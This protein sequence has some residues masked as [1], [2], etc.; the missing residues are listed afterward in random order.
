MSLIHQ[1]GMT[2]D[3]PLHLRTHL[4]DAEKWGVFMLGDLGVFDC[5][6][7]MYKLTLVVTGF[8][9]SIIKRGLHGG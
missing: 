9:L 3:M 8:G 5:V 7:A 4:S 2:G 1:Q 6:W